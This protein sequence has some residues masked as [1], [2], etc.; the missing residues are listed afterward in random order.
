[1]RIAGL[2]K[3]QRTVGG[4]LTRIEALHRFGDLLCCPVWMQ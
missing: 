2:R 3:K 4:A 1:M